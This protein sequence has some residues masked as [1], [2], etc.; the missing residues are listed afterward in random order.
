MAELRRIEQVAEHNSVALGLISRLGTID[1]SLKV[2]FEFSLHPFFAT[3][4]E[5]YSNC[6]STNNN[7]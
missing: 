1:P 5:Y 7:T 2:H 6:P 3:A 4:V